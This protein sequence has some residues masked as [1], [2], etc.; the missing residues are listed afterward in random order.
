MES[1]GNSDHNCRVCQPWGRAGELSLRQ[2]P[3][4]R[5][6]TGVEPGDR[7]AE[8]VWTQGASSGLD[9]AQVGLCLHHVEPS[10]PH[11]LWMLL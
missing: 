11:P 1:Q 4:M 9:A 8:N 7:E 3:P 2:Q 6:M 5:G 10:L